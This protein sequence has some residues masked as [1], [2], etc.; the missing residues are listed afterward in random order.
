MAAVCVVHYM[1]LSVVLPHSPANLLSVFLKSPLGHTVPRVRKPG[2]FPGENSEALWCNDPGWRVARS[3]DMGNIKEN[4]MWVIR[5]EAR[6]QETHYT[7]STQSCHDDISWRYVPLLHSIFWHCQQENISLYNVLDSLFLRHFSLVSPAIVRP[8]LCVHSPAMVMDDG[9]SRIFW[10]PGAIPL[11]IDL[12][13]GQRHY[14]V[15]VYLHK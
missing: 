8:E 14:D 15:H 7:R 5:W 1:Q 6:C 9:M 11:Q 4:K 12:A 10:Y 3:Q 13:K 2:L